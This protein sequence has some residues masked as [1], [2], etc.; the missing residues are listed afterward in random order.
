MTAFVVGRMNIQR[1]DWMEEYFAKVPGLV[2]E[3]GGEFLVKGGEPQTLEGN[4]AAPDA[5]FVIRFPSS[6]AALGFWS[7][8]EFAPL[9]ELR[10]TGS[11]L[12]AQLYSGL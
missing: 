10:Q 12:E 2:E 1:R 5:A 3:H 8:A 11:T 4:D 9:I 7:S 6:E